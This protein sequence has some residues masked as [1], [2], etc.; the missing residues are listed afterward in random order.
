MP[1]LHSFG[2]DDILQNRMVARPKFDFVMYSGSAYINNDGEFLGE[3]ITTGTINLFEYNVDRNG[4]T[5]SLIYPYVIKG[6]GLSGLIFRNNIL[7]REQYGSLDNNSVITGSYPLASSITRQYFNATTYPFPGGSDTAKD[8]YVTNRKELIALQNTMNYYRYVSNE[9]AYTGS[10]VSGTVNMLQIPS[11]MFGEQIKRGTVSLKFYYTGSLIDE[12]T[13]SRQNGELISTMGN[14]SGSTVG[15]V[16]Y[17]EGFVL[18]TSSADISSNQ[19]S[20]LGTVTQQNA[21]WQ[22]FGAFDLASTEGVSFATASLFSLSFE[23]TQKIP[24]TTMFATAQPG[25]LNNSLNPTW[26]SSS[27]ADWRSKTSIGDSG[28]I[29]PRETPIKNTINSQYCNYEAEFQKQTFITEIGI[30]DKD[31]NLIGVA[32]LANPV[33]KKESD[34]YTFKLKLDM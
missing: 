7:T 23:G 12:A 6:S 19:D 13:D 16:L 29:E 32:K 3:N 11:I 33:Q 34:N 9:Y 31:K 24:T 8:T 2:P 14:T 17:N 1:Y 4:S 10:Y 25:D 5:Q 15:V 27:A 21:S 22:Y 26:V 18:L 28:Y 20:Y 30:F